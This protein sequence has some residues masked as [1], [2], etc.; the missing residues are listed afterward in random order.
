ME[1]NATANNPFDS[2]NL[3]NH[4]I[5]NVGDRSI[6]SL[7]DRSEYFNALETSNRMIEIYNSDL[8][9]PTTDLSRGIIPCLNLKTR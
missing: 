5:A 4:S 9:G 1:N 2:A 3:S 7:K 6:D 8:D